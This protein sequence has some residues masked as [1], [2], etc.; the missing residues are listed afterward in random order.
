MPQ[1]EIARELPF[2]SIIMPVFNEERYIGGILDAV[3]KQDYP[4]ERMEIIVADG[5]STDQTR[6]I[7][8]S[9]QRGHGNLRL[10]YN[11]DRIVS[12][13]LNRAI[14]CA[15]GEIIVRLDGHCEYP[16][17]YLRRVV[18]LRE[19]L[20]ADSVGGTLVP[21]GSGYIQSA[22]GAAYYSPVGIGGT[23]LKAVDGV[24]TVREVDAV[25]GGCWRVERLRKVGGFDEEMV[26]NQDDELSFRL[27]KASGRIYQCTSIKVKYHV[28]D[29]FKKLFMQF[30]QYGYW[31][32]RVVKKHPKQASARHFVPALF[33]LFI[34]GCALAAPFTLYALYG[35]SG[36]LGI[37]L[38]VLGV[39]S[40][41]QTASKDRKLWP[42]IV[43]ALCSMHF[44]YGGGFVLGWVR[45]WI[46]PLPTDSIFERTTR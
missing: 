28:R 3:L 35:L 21:I 1:N 44:G 43:L 8:V 15:R 17:D 6:D 19:R 46:G 27:R 40:F 29:S 2:V 42:G 39:V 14:G 33:V 23:A 30:A 13:G 25:H 20:G 36:G 38:S 10:I 26:R 7:I 41:L 16:K 18:L 34:T 31:K 32:V 12:T 24:E 37:Y 22:I 45:S 9:F 4:S 5:A 11:P